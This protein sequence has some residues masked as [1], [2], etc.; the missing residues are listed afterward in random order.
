MIF[1]VPCAKITRQFCTKWEKIQAQIRLKFSG[2][3]DL[4]YQG[5]YSHKFVITIS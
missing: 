2:F 5:I 1:L 3:K 4:A